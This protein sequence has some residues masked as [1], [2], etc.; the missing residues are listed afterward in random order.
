MA[1]YRQEDDGQLRIV[2]AQEGDHGAASKEGA[3]EASLAMKVIAVM[4]ALWF[5]MF[6][7]ELTFFT[8]PDTVIFMVFMTLSVVAISFMPTHGHH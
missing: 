3:R 2:E 6:L 4:I 8:D 5:I 7:A 1:R